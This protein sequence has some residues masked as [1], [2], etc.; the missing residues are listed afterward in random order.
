[1]TDPRGYWHPHAKV[2]FQI[3]VE[4]FANDAP[5]PVQL[6]I[7]DSGPEAFGPGVEHTKGDGRDQFKSIGYDIVPYACNVE[8]N[9]YREADA[10]R[11]TIPL[12]KMPFDPRVI[13]A[14]TVQVFGGVIDPVI[15]RREFDSDD[16][17]LLPDFTAGG[18]SNQIF[19]GF[20]DDWEVEL[21]EHNVLQV[22]ARD[23]TA[24][25][26][27]AEIK[28]NIPSNLPKTMRL[29]DVVREIL[30]HLPGVTGLKVVV[31]TAEVGN[32]LPKLE[33]IKPPNWFNSAGKTKKGKKRSPNDSQ[34]MSYWDMVTDLCVAAGFIVFFRIPTLEQGGGRVNAIQGRPNTPELVIADP[35]TYYKESVE[36][37]GEEKIDPNKVRTFVYGLNLD[38]LTVRR[39]F[40]G[41]KTPTIE[42]RSWDTRKGKRVTGRFPR[43]E[44]N[45]QPS[46]SGKGDREE[47]QVMLLRDISGP[48][49]QK[50]IDAS[51]ASIYQQLSRG[52]FEVKM[53]T[54]T[55]AALPRNLDPD[56][57]SPRGTATPAN[58]DADMFAMMSGQTI[59]VG[60][61]RENVETDQVTSPGKA[62]GTLGPARS[63]LM[64]RAG[65]RSDLADEIAKAMGNQFIQK[66][67]RVQKNI[68]T[69]AHSRG[70]E[71]EVHAINFLDI[72]QS[73]QSDLKP[74]KLVPKKKAGV[75]RS[76]VGEAQASFPPGESASFPPEESTEGS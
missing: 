56:G 10:C 6:T 76:N 13:R 45:N 66:E 42:V 8:R 58:V 63:E 38:S 30:K 35:R 41:V 62:A 55:L 15:F 25:L 18:E 52:E 68:M 65:I 44:V 43:R 46:T 5:L 69:W 1:M 36:G 29:D 14:A 9:S 59:L 54:K 20:V 67:F 51:A 39:K 12:E 40:Q 21:S 34:K 75:V 70:W 22:T 71:F 73:V 2:R 4:N 72:R 57:V 23:L 61:D 74:D 11:I 26:V 64:Q 47:V 16:G 33:E 31:E 60:V 17:I 48:N 3:R 7:P 49:A 53:K 19:A 24:F 27:D 28:E 50:R 37:W 32:K